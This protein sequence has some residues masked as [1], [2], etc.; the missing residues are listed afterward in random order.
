MKLAVTGIAL[1]LGLVAPPIAVAQSRIIEGSVE[2]DLVSGPVE[3]AVLL[4]KEYREDGD[5]LPLLLSLHGDGGNR[6]V[7]AQRQQA[8]FDELWADGS[9]PPVVVATPSAN[10]SVYMN[11]RNGDERWEDFMVDDFLSHLRNLPSPNGPGGAAAHG[12]LDGRHRIA[13]ARI[14]TP[15]PL[16]S[17]GRA[18]AGDPSRSELG[19]GQAETFPQP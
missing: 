4:P 10:R 6:D 14:Q 9:F 3:Y 12:G 5:R 7:L 18:R 16:R 19:R 17:R 1:A 11:A 15:R 8:L 2:T 13:P